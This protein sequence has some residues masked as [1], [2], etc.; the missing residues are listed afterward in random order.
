M[1]LGC[2]KA[3]KRKAGQNLGTGKLMV[4]CLLPHLTR[5]L[6]LPC[7]ETRRR[8]NIHLYGSFQV[9]FL[10]QA[11]TF[12]KLVDVRRVQSYSST[13]NRRHNNQKGYD[14]ERKPNEEICHRCQFYKGFSLKALSPSISKKKR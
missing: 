11:E 13:S 5:C 12:A 2:L 4:G 1:R 9:F 6:K 3:G 7:E 8:D 14:F 10:F